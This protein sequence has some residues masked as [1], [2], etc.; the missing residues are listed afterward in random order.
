VIWDVDH[1]KK[2]NDTFGHKAGDKVLRTI[3]R[4]LAGSIRETD[5]IARYGGEEFVHLM[6]GAEL[7]NCVAVA[8]KLRGKIEATGF[9]FREQAVTITVSC[10]VTQFR[11]GDSSESWFERADRALYKAKQAGRNRCVSD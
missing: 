10:G 1:F 4:N 7:E 2:V 3:A 8:D 6:T 5:F 9:H 11:D